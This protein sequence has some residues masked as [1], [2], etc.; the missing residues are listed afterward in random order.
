MDL[1]R[2]E[3]YVERRPCQELRVQ[4]EEGVFFLGKS[5]VKSEWYVIFEPGWDSS[6]TTFERIRLQDI[7]VLIERVYPELY[8]W[9]VLRFP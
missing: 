1:Q 4:G 2:L 3:L 5:Y 8:A 9:L 7:I 6:P